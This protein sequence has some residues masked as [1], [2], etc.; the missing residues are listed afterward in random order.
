MKK[1][2]NELNSS[3]VMDIALMT[4]NNFCISGYIHFLGSSNVYNKKNL[5]Y[6]IVS[7]YSIILSICTIVYIVN[8]ESIILI[9]LY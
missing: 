9:D 1:E 5:A 3:G 7:I 4:G 2:S 6:I 8:I